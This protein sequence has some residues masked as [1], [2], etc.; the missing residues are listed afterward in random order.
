LLY[1]CSTTLNT[2]VHFKFVPEN[3][4]K[5]LILLSCLCICMYVLNTPTNSSIQMELQAV[6]YTCHFLNLFG[7]GWMVFVCLS[8]QRGKK[9]KR[10]KKRG[11]NV[12]KPKRKKGEKKEKA[13]TRRRN[14]H[15]SARKKTIGGPAVESAHEPAAL[16]PAASFSAVLARDWRLHLTM[17]STNTRVSSGV[18]PGGTSTT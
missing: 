14:T 12:K 9:I 3:R 5:Y 7:Q 13:L 6:N 16:A 1:R 11:S 10:K 18:L 17:V 4:S 2:N 8:Q 15:P